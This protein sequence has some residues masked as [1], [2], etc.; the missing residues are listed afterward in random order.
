VVGSTTDS[1]WKLN[2]GMD[3]DDDDDNNNNNIKQPISLLVA[4]PVFMVI[5]SPPFLL[6]TYAS[7]ATW[8]ALCMHISLHLHKVGSTAFKLHILIIFSNLHTLCGHI[9]F[10]PASG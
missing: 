1:G 4:C 6:S 10:S 5:V 8:T 2:Y 7:S 9:V 3:D